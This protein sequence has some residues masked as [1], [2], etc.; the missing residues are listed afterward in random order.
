MFN[1]KQFFYLYIDVL[2][3]MNVNWTLSTVYV[4]GTPF[5]RKLAKCLWCLD[6]HH[7]NF[8]TR[9]FKIP[10]RFSQFQGYND[11]K[12]KRVK[13]PRLSCVELKCHIDELSGT[14]VQPWFSNT[15]FDLLRTDAEEL[16][17]VMSNYS[18]NF[19]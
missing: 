17:D 5:V 13:E 8:T 9:G 18:N 6:T 3:S 19:S 16:V 2:C 10:C 15:K 7:V 11:Y 1:G 14:L 12:R 4:T